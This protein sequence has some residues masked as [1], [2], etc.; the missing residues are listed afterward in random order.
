MKLKTWVVF[1]GSQ[2]GWL[3]C[4]LAGWSQSSTGPTFFGES[5]R[6]RTGVHRGS[7]WVA[8][9]SSW[10][11]MLRKLTHPDADIV[12]FGLCSARIV[13]EL[14]WTL[15]TF[16]GRHILSGCMTQSAPCL[17]LALHSVL[18]HTCGL[19]TILHCSCNPHTFTVGLRLISLPASGWHRQ[20]MHA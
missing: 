17:N 5:P 1:T 14:F 9:S 6:L 13:T 16:F 7:A 4:E 15:H 12:P 2:Q 10:R 8:I 19:Q 11:I 3:L 20:H 18:L